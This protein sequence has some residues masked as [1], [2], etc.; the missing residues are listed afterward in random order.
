MCFSDFAP[1]IGTTKTPA[2]FPWAIGQAMESWA[3]VVFFLRAMV[4]SAER[5]PRFF[6]M[7]TV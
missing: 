6:S 2:R 5:S 7:L 4:S 3:S 1:G